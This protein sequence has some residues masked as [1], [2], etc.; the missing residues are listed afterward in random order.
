MTQVSETQG[1]PKPPRRLSPSALAMYEACPKA[2]EYQYVL[3]ETG[4]DR[5]SP[6]LVIGN[7][8]HHALSLLFGLPVE[9]RSVEVL[10]QALRSVWPQYVKA[11]AFFDRDEEIDAG[12]DALALLSEFW[13][14]QDCSI[15][16]RMREDWVSC[17][18][19]NGLRVFGR[20]DRI[21]DVEGG[22]AV[23][24]YKTGKRAVTAKELPQTPAAKV[25]A[26]AAQER[27]RLPVVEVRL[28]Y[29]A[30]GKTVV[31]R[32]TP[33]DLEQARR[34]LVQLTDSVHAAEVF[35]AKPGDACRF[36]AFASVCEDKDRVRLEDLIVSQEVGF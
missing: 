24:D 15:K 29:L 16:P 25:Y 8:C 36:C 30:L 9:D 3:K 12:R 6:V 33:Q 7:A 4:E 23:I 5:P 31:W 1:R 2:F 22:I 18:L 10:H 35:A 13:N 26:L 32:P 11:D 19:P 27:F 21:D 28:V 20:V 17:A 34:D 14:T